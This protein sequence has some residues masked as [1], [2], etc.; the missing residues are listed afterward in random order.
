MPVMNGLH[1][2][3][4]LKMDMPTVPI[5]LF[6]AQK[7]RLSGSRASNAGISAVVSKTDD[8]DA[9]IRQVRALL[10]PAEQQHQTN[11]TVLRKQ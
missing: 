6:T 3:H 8:I 10:K 5:I 9:L 11:E 1:A 2:A 7:A 4:V